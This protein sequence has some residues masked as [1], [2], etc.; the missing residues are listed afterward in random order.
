MEVWLRMAGVFDG[1]YSGE[2]EGKDIPTAEHKVIQ[3]MQNPK[4]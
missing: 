4:S 2:E 1:N 3:N